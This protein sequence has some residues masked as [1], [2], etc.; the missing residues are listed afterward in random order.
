MEQGWLELMNL[1]DA[2]SPAVHEIPIPIPT[3]VIEAAD[4]TFGL[5]EG[6]RLIIGA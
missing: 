2:L 1:I 4:I 3:I 6:R 5:L